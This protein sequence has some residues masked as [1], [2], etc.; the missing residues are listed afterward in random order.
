MG[1]HDCKSIIYVFYG[2]PH[3]RIVDRLN[4]FYPLKTLLLIIIIMIIIIIIIIINQ[5]FARAPHYIYRAK[6][7][8]KN[9]SHGKAKYVCMCARVV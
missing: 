5:Q 4:V 6:H 8:H 2:G 1:V 9:L 7:F 3:G